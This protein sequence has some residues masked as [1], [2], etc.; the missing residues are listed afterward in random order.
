MTVQSIQRSFALLRALAL[1]PVGVTELAERVDLPKSTVAR[2]LA[3]LEEE[4]AVEQTEAGGEYRLGSGLIDLAGSAPRGRNLVAAARPHLLELAES[5]DEVAGLSIIDGGQVYYLDQTESSSNIQ[6]R[7]WT[8]EHAPLHAV[9]SG[10]V[11]LAHQR[12]D[13]IN[14]YLTSPLVQC[15]PWTM[16]D[17]GEL[18]DRL[19]QIRSIGYAWVYE[20]FAEELNSVAAPIFES[21]GHVE[22]AL[23]VHGPAYRFPNPDDT[24]DLGMAVIEAAGRLSM[25]LS[26]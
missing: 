14:R 1:G 24:H 2:L 18:R 16:T 12:P 21:G 10:L 11:I 17:P 22:A 15:T 26:D 7:D 6:V 4:Q 5:L 9:P 23:H 25:Q 20:E 19:E 3:S 8:G 13:F